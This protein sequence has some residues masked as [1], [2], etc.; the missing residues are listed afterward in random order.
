[1]AKQISLDG[2]TLVGIANDEEGEV[3]GDTQFQFEQ[4]GD[5]I[6][7]QYS[8]GEIVEGHLIGAFDGSQWDIR[9]V[10]MNEDGDTASGHS[11]GEVSLLDDGRVR[12]EDEWAWESKPGTG[13]SIL[14]EIES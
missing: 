6:Y 14:E 1:M 11:T 9:Y 3:N 4:A 8:G 2:R 13:E 10:Q 7:A 5:R 12:V